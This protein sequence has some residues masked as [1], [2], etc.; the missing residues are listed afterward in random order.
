VTQVLS[1]RAE[2]LDVFVSL[3]SEI[4]APSPS[5]DYYDRMCEAVCRVSSMQRVALFLYDEA[6]RRV[7]AAGSHHLDPEVLADFHATLDESPVA[8]RALTEDRVLVVSEDIPHAIPAEYARRLG[9]STVTCVPLSAAGRWFGVLFADRGGGHFDITDTERDALWT[10]GKVA[11][12]AASARIARREEERTRRLSDRIDLAREIH[13][14]VVQRLFGVSLALSAEH[15]LTPQE[16]LRCREEIRD[17]LADLR[18]ALRRPLATTETETDTSL[19]EELDRLA[20][21]YVEVPVQV[22]WAEGFVVP[23]RLEPL[24]QSVLAEAFRN[25]HKH[26]EPTLV[27]VEVGRDEDALFMEVQNDGVR[28]SSRGTGMG[29]RLAQ[30]EALQQGGV[31]EFGRLGRRRWR[32]RLVVPLVDD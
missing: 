6:R 18:T 10:L 4:D 26:A 20:R 23:G 19:R 17:A 30:F 12:L 32:L 11:A 2:S 3:L 29:L 31:L 21:R 9:L 8:R 14:Q 25:V 5:R 7:V 27:V 16:R 24:T 22:G 28:E 15:E 13:E 1:S